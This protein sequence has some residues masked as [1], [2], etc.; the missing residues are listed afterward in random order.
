MAT[1]FYLKSD[2]FKGECQDKGFENTIKLHSWSWGS[3][4]TASIGGSEGLSGGT[5]S[6]ADL[7]VMK[8]FDMSSPEIFKHITMGTS[9]AK[10]TL[11]ATKSTGK[12]SPEIFLEITLDKVYFTSQ[13][14]S[15]SSEI[16]VESVSLAFGQAK[17]EYKKQNEAGG[18]LTSTGA[19][20]YNMITKVTS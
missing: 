8:D 20:T 2:D 7:S 3:S 6:L 18:S 11:Q 12:G 9:I 4:N 17:V 13:Q 10:A 19:V 5:V 16:P 15:A 14:L 1:N